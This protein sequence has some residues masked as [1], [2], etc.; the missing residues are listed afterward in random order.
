MTHRC[1]ELSIQA[2]PLVEAGPG[3]WLVSGCAGAETTVGRVTYG[4]WGVI[5]HDLSSSPVRYVQSLRNGL[6]REEEDGCM[7][8]LVGRSINLNSQLTRPAV[9]LVAVLGMSRQSQ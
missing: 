7:E 3:F 6:R 4:W 8:R 1:I 9:A 5:C 2:A